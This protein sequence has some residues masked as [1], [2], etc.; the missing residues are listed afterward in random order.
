MPTLPNS[1]AF[2]KIPLEIYSIYLVK[3]EI[4]C[5]CKIYYKLSVSFSAK[6]RLFHYFFFFFSN[7][8]H[9]F[10]KPYNETE[11]ATPVA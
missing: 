6:F 5:I 11:I 9:V 10:H 3:K 1:N 8:P 4:Y 2:L 7:N